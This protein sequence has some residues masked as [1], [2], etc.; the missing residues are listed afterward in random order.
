MAIDNL[1]ISGGD[2]IQ[3]DTGGPNAVALDDSGNVVEVHVGTDRLFYRV[4]EVDCANQTITWELSIQDDTSGSN[5]RP[6]KRKKQQHA[7]GPRR[8]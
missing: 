8:H 7:G 6:P 3:Y 2:S 4:G 5:A 1:T